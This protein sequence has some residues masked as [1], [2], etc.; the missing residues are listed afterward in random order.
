MVGEDK[1]KKNKNKQTN[2]QSN[3]CV[4][5]MTKLIYEK[6]VC[7]PAAVS[8]CGLVVRYYASI[9]GTSKQKDLSSIHF[10]FPFSLKIMDYGP[11]LRFCPHN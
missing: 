6:K 4:R 7:R 1:N 3:D 9:M 8:Q 5:Q 11:V 2:K 10:G